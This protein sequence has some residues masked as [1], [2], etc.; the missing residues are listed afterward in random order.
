M[1]KAANRQRGEVKIIGPGGEEFK[2][3]LTLGA[4]AQIEEELG[5]E[6]LTEIDTVMGKARMKDVLTIFIALLH[7]G[8][9]EEVTRKDMMK[10]DVTIK[11]LMESIRE[12]FKAA[13][14]DSEEDE[15]KEGETQP[16]N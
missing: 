11:E 12:T 1:T 6:S 5:V 10:W 7:G 13:G 8:G 9:H 14:F 16:G 4:I 2:L 15:D 3:C